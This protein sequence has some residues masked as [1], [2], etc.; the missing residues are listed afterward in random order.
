MDV[1]SQLFRQNSYYSDQLH[2]LGLRPLAMP[3]KLPIMLW[4]NAPEFRL[5]CSN[6]APYTIHY[7]PQIQEFFSGHSY[8]Q[9]WSVNYY[10]RF[11]IP[12]KIYILYKFCRLCYIYLP[13]MLAFI[14]NAFAILL[15]SK[16]YW[17]NRLKPDSALSLYGEMNWG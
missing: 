14:F 3:L 12:C 5:L 6:Y 16:L 11:T 17:Y 10:H 1:A 7:A 4:S 2:G 15:C 9:L 8:L 13:I